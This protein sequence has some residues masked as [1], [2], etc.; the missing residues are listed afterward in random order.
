MA[1]DSIFGISSSK[2][3]IMVC[4]DITTFW[5]CDSSVYDLQLGYHIYIYIYIYTQLGCYNLD[6][7]DRGALL[8]M[9]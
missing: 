7:N 9:E 2:S 5:S 1:R 6:S 3:S 4:F 8:Y